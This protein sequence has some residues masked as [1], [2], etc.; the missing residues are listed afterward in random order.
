VTSGR[1][2]G[3]A[4]EGLRRAWGVPALE[5]HESMASTNERALE[6]ADEGAAPWTV[7]VADEQTRGKGRR[8]AAWI[9]PRKAGLWM[10]V[11]VHGVEPG[12]PLP[13]VV[14]LACAEAIES[15]AGAL[16]VGLKWPNDLLVGGRKVG[17]ILCGGAGDAVVVGIGINVSA[18]PEPPADGAAHPPLPATSLEAETGNPL[19]CNILAGAIM[20]RLRA[21]AGAR[22]RSLEGLMDEIGRRDVLRGR[23][24]RTEQEGA[25]RAAGIEASGALLLDRGDA[26]RAR[27]VSG[28][29]RLS[30]GDAGDGG[31]PDPGNRAS[32]NR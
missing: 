22:R 31:M 21:R 3:V 1:W 30:S 7:V 26:G 12:G 6:L 20:E 17:G 24:V 4:V 15:V 16:R 13:L 28:G 29:V 5:A 23:E 10:S 2:D 19:R 11:I 14:G 18:A 27:V 25:G 9:S 8:G 32:G